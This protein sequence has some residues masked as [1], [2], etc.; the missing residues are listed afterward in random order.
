MLDGDVRVLVD[1]RN[2]LFF[3]ANSVRIEEGIES[4]KLARQEREIDPRLGADGHELE[5]DRD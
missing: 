5:R 2:W 4:V 3:A 1:W